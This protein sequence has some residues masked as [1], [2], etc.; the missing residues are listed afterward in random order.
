MSTSLPIP[1]LFFLLLAFTTCSLAVKIS[2]TLG[3]D[4][5]N[6]RQEVMLS[7]SQGLVPGQESSERRDGI[8][9]QRVKPQD[10]KCDGTHRLLIVEEPPETGPSRKKGKKTKPPSAAPWWKRRPKRPQFPCL[11]KKGRKKS[12]PRLA[13]GWPSAWPPLEPVAR[14]N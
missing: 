7:A 8:Y 2:S 3:P 12:P 6:Q 4:N 14:R 5:D 9:P 1:L 11:P 10:P 13:P